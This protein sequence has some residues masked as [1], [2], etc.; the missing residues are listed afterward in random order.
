MARDYYNK[1]LV[2]PDVLTATDMLQRMKE[3][4]TFAIMTQIKPGKA[5]ELFGDSAY[6]F[7]QADITVPYID[8]LAGN[9]FH[10]GDPGIKQKSGA[11]YEI[12]GIS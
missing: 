8:Y 11:R 5:E 7:A 9:R 2:R 10:A 1:G 6:E 12:F 4:K 3:G